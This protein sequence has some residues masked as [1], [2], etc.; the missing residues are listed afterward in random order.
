MNTDWALH[1]VFIFV[2]LTICWNKHNHTLCILL[3]FNNI[4]TIFQIMRIVSTR[5]SFL[6]LDSIFALSY[7]LH[8]IKSALEKRYLWACRANMG[9]RTGIGSTSN[10]R[11]NVDLGVHHIRDIPLCFHSSLSRFHY[12]TG[13]QYLHSLFELTANQLYHVCRE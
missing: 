6:I 8:N 2:L 5:N 9:L 1:L 13:C 7:F 10:V 12:R 11:N 3:N 4:R